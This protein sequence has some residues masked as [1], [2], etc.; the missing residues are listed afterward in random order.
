MGVITITNVN[1]EGDYYPFCKEKK[2]IKWIKKP[3]A[4]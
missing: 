4:S 1:E 2:S 3:I